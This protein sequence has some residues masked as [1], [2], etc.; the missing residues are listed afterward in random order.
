MWVSA[1]YV[2]LPFG[3]TSITA[4]KDDGSI[5]YIPKDPDNTDYQ[6]IMELVAEGKLVIAPADA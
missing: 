6:N 2:N 5:W 4:V 1:K 3:G